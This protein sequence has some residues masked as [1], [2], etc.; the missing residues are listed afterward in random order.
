MNKTYEVKIVRLLRD[1]S[2][3]HSCKTWRIRINGKYGEWLERTDKA[4][5]SY[6][7]VYPNS[8][9]E[10]G[11]DNSGKPRW[12]VIKPEF[13]TNTR[14]KTKLYKQIKNCLKKFRLENN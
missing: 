12:W 4:E 1:Q 2:K 11:L 5:D 9:C 6:I 13:L 8:L 7:R 10:K 3:Q 14:T